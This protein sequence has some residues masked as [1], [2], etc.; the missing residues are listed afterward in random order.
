MPPFNL[1]MVQPAMAEFAIIN[2]IRAILTTE[3]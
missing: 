1:N 3:L 2:E